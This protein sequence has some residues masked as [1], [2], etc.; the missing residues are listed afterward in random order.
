MLTRLAD[1]II[2]REP[3]ATATGIAA[4]ITAALGVAAAFGLDIT[5]E[6]IAAIGALA[7]ALAGWAGRRAV[8]PITSPADRQVRR[9]L[10]GT[11]RAETAQDGQLGILVAI[12]VIL[13]LAMVGLFAICTDDDDQALGLRL[14]AATGPA[15]HDGGDCDPEWDDCGDYDQRYDQ[16]NN[17]DRNRNRNRNRGAFSPGPFDRSP[18]EMHD[19]CISL[20]CSSGRD[21]R[22]RRD[23]SPPEEARTQSLF[24][25][26]FE[27]VKAF[28]LS[29]IKSGIEMG[30]LFAETT[31]T[32]VENLLFGIA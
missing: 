20:D 15:Y 28:V 27:G 32:F 3:V 30:R 25:P 24:P 12:L 29:T 21:D 14:I 9:L 8:T 4:V 16:W 17:E 31:I 23:E 5:A 19:V 2:G 6:Q 22:R 7:A 1:W 26:S 13:V 18:V 10:D 11:Q